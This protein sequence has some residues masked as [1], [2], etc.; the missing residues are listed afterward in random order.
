MQF[1]HRIR[2]AGISKRIRPAGISKV[3]RLLSRK[4]F[5]SAAYL[6]DSASPIPLKHPDP[7]QTFKF[8]ENLVIKNTIRY[9]SP[10]AVVSMLNPWQLQ[11]TEFEF[12]FHLDF[13]MP[14]AQAEQPK[15][16]PWR[17]IW[18]VTTESDKDCIIERSSTNGGLCAK[19]GYTDEVNQKQK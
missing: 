15:S 4:D 1:I 18:P 14:Q 6:V 10:L 7:P 12:Q 8:P 13:I 9:A 11:Q 17:A 2:P 19:T 3:A 16:Q 5:R